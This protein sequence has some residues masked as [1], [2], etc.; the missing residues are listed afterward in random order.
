MARSE[1]ALI[2]QE[3]G[4]QQTGCADDACAV[5][6]GRIM[7]V[8]YIIT[9]S[10]GKVG[11]IF[12]VNMKLINVETSQI[13]VS[14]NLDKK[15]S[16]EEILTTGTVNLVDEFE[17]KF[18]LL[19]K[20]KGEKSS[21]KD[22]SNDKQKLKRKIIRQIIIGAVSLG[23]AG[24]GVALN[25]KGETLISERDDAYSSYKNANSDFNIYKSV[26]NEK[27]DN[28][29]QNSILRNVFYGL[30]GAAGVTF[31]ITLFF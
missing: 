28:I 3:Q 22:S 4:F 30:A 20:K 10:I 15:S 5:E 23:C 31:T 11:K 2:L 14:V 29:K 8:N 9:G 27:T 25:S 21:G 13:L 1:M 6:I 18:N 19:N 17:R 26:V 12:S 24:A 16:V 7:G